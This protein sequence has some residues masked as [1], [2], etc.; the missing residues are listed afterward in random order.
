MSGGQ[1]RSSSARPALVLVCAALVAPRLAQAWK[2]DAPRA[3]ADAQE[4]PLAPAGLS[5]TAAEEL[6]KELWVA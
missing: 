6:A 2:A 4:A 5:R 3:V 1:A